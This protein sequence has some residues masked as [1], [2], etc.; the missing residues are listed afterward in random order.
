MPNMPFE[1]PVPPVQVPRPLASP[2]RRALLC[3]GTGVALGAALA[4]VELVHS[5][6]PPV[7]PATPG[8]APAANPPARWQN[9]SGIQQCQPQRFLV[10]RDE[11]VL[12]QALREAPNG[13][14]RCVGAGHSFTALVPTDQWL[15]S[16]DQLSGVSE[17]APGKDTVLVQGGT[18]LAMASRLLDA[19][20]L[21]LRNLPDVDVQSYAGA[22]STATHGTGMQLPALHADVLGLRLVTARGEVIECNAQQRPDLLAAARVSLGSLGVITQARVRVVPAYSLH[23][24]VWL[25]PAMQL[26]ERAPELARKHRNFEFYYLPFTGYA[27]GIAHDIDTSG[28]VLM[29]HA[30]DEDV[31]RDLRRLRDWLGH[32][33]ALRRKVA[34]WAIDP[35]QKEEAKNRAWRL[36]A[37]QRPTRFNET[38]YHV[39]QEVGVACAK[40]VIAALEKRNGVY[41]PMEFRFVAA[42]EAAWLSPFYQRASCSIAVHAAVGEPYDYLV[43]EI[44]PLFRKYQG[45]PHW[46]KLHDL[47]AAQLAALYPRWDDFLALRRELDPQ[48]RFLNAHL[49]KLFGETA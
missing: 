12:A 3:T 37:T 13:P 34:G 21:A 5:A 26:L 27:A 42:D 30:A 2:I 28:Q 40:E 15:V 35:D 9:W 10:P 20:G 43:S 32:F 49:R 16:L 44:G 38:E 4:P 46:G 19:A 1:T 8:A 6:S 17:M 22:I 36:L 24:R 45:R 29:P 41:F 33:P 48:G 39:P 11:A 25:E 23:R 47:G 7:A 31:L 18:R 14:V